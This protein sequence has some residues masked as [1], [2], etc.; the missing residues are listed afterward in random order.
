MH[1]R[2]GR[3]RPLA[4]IIEA[5]FRKRGLLVKYEEWQAVA[6]WEDVVG[7]RIA[8]HATAE[9]VVKGV[10][11]VKTED[12]IWNYELTQQKRL[13]I[14]RLNRALGKEIIKDIRFK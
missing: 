8:A 6:K 13:L 2:R 5:I 4:G 14:E 12:S 1:Y 11:Y 9:R 7:E 3:P 10:L